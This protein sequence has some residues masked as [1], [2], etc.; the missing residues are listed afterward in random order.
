MFVIKPMCKTHY[1]RNQKTNYGYRFDHY[2]MSKSKIPKS[3]FGIAKDH[4]I[5]ELSKVGRDSYERYSGVKM[6]DKRMSRLTLDDQE[7]WYRE[8]LRENGKDTPFLIY[9]IYILICKSLDIVYGD[10]PI[11]RFWFLETVARM[12]YFSYYAMLHMY[13]TFG[14]WRISVDLRKQHAEE[15]YNETKHLLIMEILGGNRYYYDRFFAAHS[16]VV[17][18]MILITLFFFSPNLSYKFSE[19]LENHAVDTYDQ[20]IKEN[21]KLLKRLPVPIL[22]NEKLDQ[23]HESLYDVF[24]EIRNDEQEHADSMSKLTTLNGVNTLKDTDD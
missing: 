4:L 12:P 10:R 3:F 8:S 15:E 17:Y 1:P 20:F 6:M 9:M 22:I 16:A 23:N 2:E 13:E 7:I 18:Y 19:L 14:W 11:Q 5:L 24:L 21:E